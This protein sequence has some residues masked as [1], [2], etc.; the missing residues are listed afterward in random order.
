MYLRLILFAFLVISCKTP[1]DDV[2]EISD[3]DDYADQHTIW[4][5]SRIRSLT[6][7]EGW[8]SLTGLHW[9][10]EGDNRIGSEASNDHQLPEPVAK[11][12]GLISLNNG[13]IKF[14]AGGESYVTMDGERVVELELKSDADGKPSKLEHKSFIFYVIKRGE[15]YALRVKNT[16]NRDRYSLKFIP[17]FDISYSHIVEAKVSEAKNDLNLQVEDITGLIQD[18]KVEAVLEFRI[19]GKKQKLYAFDGGEEYYF[20]IFNDETSGIET[21]AGGRY[22]YVS[23]PKEG[24]DTCIL[25]F[26]R[27]VN[28]PCVFTDFAT[29]PIPPA[30]NF[31]SCRIVAGEKYPKEQ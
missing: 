6:A 17:S 18:Y 13:Q 7:P 28:P 10:K 21:Y 23:R 1:V 4:K 26:N 22:I 8:L 9:L 16:L 25:D 12:L 24:S 31:L 14:R 5:N 3:Q 30:E 29:C 2:F 20:V 11:R 27:S 15:R 19:E